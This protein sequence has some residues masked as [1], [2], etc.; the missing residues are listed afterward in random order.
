MA[1][2]Q[3]GLVEGTAHGR[4]VVDPLVL[5]HRLETWLSL[6][7]NRDIPSSLLLVSCALM[8]RDPLGERSKADS[9]QQHTPPLDSSDDVGAASSIEEDDSQVQVRIRSLMEQEAQTLETARDASMRLV[10]IRNE[11]K[12]L[13]YADARDSNSSSSI[14]DAMYADIHI[15][16]HE[17][18]VGEEQRFETSDG[19][20]L[21]KLDS[22]SSISQDFHHHVAKASY[23]RAQEAAGLQSDQPIPFSHHLVDALMDA[24]YRTRVAQGVSTPKALGGSG[25]FVQPGT[26][27]SR[28]SP[29]DQYD[30]ER[31][32]DA[33]HTIRELLP[34]L[35]SYDYADFL[36]AYEELVRR[37]EGRQQMEQRREALVQLSE[38]LDRQ[39][40]VTALEE[41]SENDYSSVSPKSKRK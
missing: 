10:R 1:C 24:L 26:S 14:R 39:A 19:R 34:E 7:L 36:K 29:R 3:R 8:M 18:R 28:V 15:P 37:Q 21:D 4:V 25:G 12:E 5:R 22:R 35:G 38:M 31:A 32:R 20:T 11:L 9:V 41:A 33:R 6:S 40:A 30:N 2:E 23:S 27:S 13:G 17:S 16:T